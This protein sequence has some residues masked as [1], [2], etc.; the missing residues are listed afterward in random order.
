MALAQA[1]RKSPPEERV[2]FKLQ[3]GVRDALLWLSVAVALYMLLA[4]SSY[5]PE[6]PAWT[7]TSGGRYS[8]AGGPLGS[9]FSDIALYLL[10]YVAFALPGLVLYSG[11]LFHRNTDSN[12]SGANEEQFHPANWALAATGLV[13]TL[14][15]IAGLVTLQTRQPWWC[16]V[17]VLKGLGVC[18]AG[19]LVGELAGVKLA[20][21]LGYVGATVFL[22]GLTFAAITLFTGV[23]WVGLAEWLG[24]TVFRL[25]HIGGEEEPEEANETEENPSETLLASV[26][27]PVV[28]ASSDPSPE[29]TPSRRNR[30]V[31]VEPSLGD[32][33]E[34]PVGSPPLSVINPKVADSSPKGESARKKVTPPIPPLSPDPDLPLLGPAVPV[35]PSVEPVITPAVSIEPVV[36]L[37]LLRKKSAEPATVLVP[38]KLPPIPLPVSATPSG[39][40]TQV[41]PVERPAA[42]DSTAS[43]VDDSLGRLSLIHI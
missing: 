27:P 30:G 11:W 10:G 31:R 28:P 24:E 12:A 13:L 22:L 29:A 40:A 15:A 43:P 38:D 18:G 20:Y 6:D 7:H 19:G 26:P 39:L 2:T 21:L 36:D 17:P 14:I 3:R 1:T 8:N 9:Y 32:L 37:D 42:P 35:T 4:L 41:L 16:Q 23:S 34:T 25:F 5:N 33:E